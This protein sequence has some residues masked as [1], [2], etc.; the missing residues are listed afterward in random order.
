MRISTRLELPTVSTQN[1]RLIWRLICPERDWS[2]SEKNG[3]G[4]GEGMS[5]RGRKSTTSPSRS[6]AIRLQEQRIGG[7]ALDLAPQAVDLH[8]DRALVHRAAAGQRRARHGFAGSDRQN[9]QHFALAVGQVND[10][11][12]LAQFAAIEMKYVRAERD[13]LQR[14]HRR[15]RAALEDIADP[16]DQFARLEWFC[17]IVVGADL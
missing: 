9:A 2:S 3:F 12:A 1:G 17:D 14:L 8:V 7:I 5:P 10:L 16:Q 6:C 4:P 13:L 15:R 11:L